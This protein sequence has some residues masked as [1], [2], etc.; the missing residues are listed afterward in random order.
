MLV[1]NLIV[2]IFL[3][4]VFFIEKTQAQS[5]LQSQAGKIKTSKIGIVYQTLSGD[6]NKAFGDSATPGYGGELALDAGGDYFR[7]FVI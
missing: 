3:F 1:K 7:Y 2:L 5:R 6:K 4:I